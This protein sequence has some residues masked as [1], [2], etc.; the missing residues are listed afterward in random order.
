[1]G[2]GIV[3]PFTAYAAR[4]SGIV[5]RSIEPA[6][7]LECGVLRERDQSLSASLSSLC[8]ELITGLFTSEAS[9]IVMK[10]SDRLQRTADAAAA[11]RKL[12]DGIRLV[13][14]DG[15]LQI[16]L[17]GDLAAILALSANE[18]PRRVSSTGLLPTLVAGHDLNQRFS[19]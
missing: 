15:E 14:E 4:N 9:A 2:C 3:D 19:G 17:E 11:L 7:H 13:P 8:A 18:N 16:E 12:I 10:R 1:L 5:F 6:S